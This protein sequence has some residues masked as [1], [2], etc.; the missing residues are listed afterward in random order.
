MKKVRFISFCSLLTVAM[1]TVVFNSCGLSKVA[2]IADHDSA[3]V[4]VA[5]STIYSYVEVM[6]QFP[7]G[8]QALT[9]WLAKNIKYPAMAQQRRIQGQVLISF[10]VTPNGDIKDETITRSVDTSLDDEVIRAIKTMPKWVSGKQNGNPRFVSTGLSIR[11]ALDANW[12]PKEQPQISIAT[13][14]GQP[15]TGKKKQA[16]ESPFNDVIIVAEKEQP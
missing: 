2:K 9:D 14:T 10:V 4:I 15:D 5:D 7:G 11:F 16:L 1:T 13:I 12:Q 3:N 8:E 6:P